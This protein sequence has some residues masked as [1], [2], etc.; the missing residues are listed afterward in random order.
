MEP[1]VKSFKDYR[2]FLLSR[3]ENK[4]IDLTQNVIKR[5]NVHAHSITNLSCSPRPVNISTID[6][7]KCLFTSRINCTSGASESNLMRTPA[8]IS[9]RSR[10]GQS[11]TSAIMEL[12]ERLE[13]VEVERS[14][15]MQEGIFDLVKNVLSCSNDEPAECHSEEF[16]NLTETNTLLQRR[17]EKC[18]AELREAHA[19][20]KSRE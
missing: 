3:L 18:E 11:S 12:R 8:R 1:K 2:T 10:G 14:I 13:Q 5:R 9:S 20:L 15:F 17:L 4:Y 6:S 19:R 16:E 7:E